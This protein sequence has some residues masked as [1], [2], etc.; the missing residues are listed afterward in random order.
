MVHWGTG[1]VNLE[2]WSEERPISKRVP[3]GRFLMIKWL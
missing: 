2:L 1:I 3:P